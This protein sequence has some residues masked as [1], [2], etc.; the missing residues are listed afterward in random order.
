MQLNDPESH[1]LS[2]EEEKVLIN[3]KKTF[4]PSSFRVAIVENKNEKEER[5]KVGQRKESNF[6]F[7]FL[8][9]ISHYAINAMHPSTEPK[10]DSTKEQN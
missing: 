3:K 10:G 2:G 5:R 1:P 6:K 4:I 9:I 8:Y 7:L